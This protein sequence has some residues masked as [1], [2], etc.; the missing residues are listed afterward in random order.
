V[1]LFMAL[2][3][4][5]ALLYPGGFSVV[6]NYFCDLLHPIAPSGVPNPGRDFALAAMVLIVPTLALFWHVV[7]ALFPEERVYVLVTRI[8]GSV[9]ALAT[10]LL[11]TPFHDAAV[12]I[13]GGFGLVAFAAVLFAL[14]RAR[15]GLLFAGGVSAALVSSACFFVWRT[16]VAGGALAPLQKLAFALFLG[17]IFVAS[18]AASRAVS[19]RARS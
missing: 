9:S 5:G 10:L 15:H 8:A 2:Y 3:A 19:D 6:R 14:P 18:L 4:L 1:V 11:L 16:G 13:G 7:V 12:E 17:W